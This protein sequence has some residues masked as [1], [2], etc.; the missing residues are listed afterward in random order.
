LSLDA[1]RLAAPRVA[2]ATFAKYPSN[3][4]LRSISSAGGLH[5]G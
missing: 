4:I 1:N 5:F 2:Y 3:L